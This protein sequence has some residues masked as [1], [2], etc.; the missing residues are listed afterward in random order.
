MSQIDF[1]RC[2]A[3]LVAVRLKIRVPIGIDETADHPALTEL[4]VVAEWDST[5]EAFVTEIDIRG[6]ALQ[7]CGEGCKFLVLLL[8]PSRTLSCHL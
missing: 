4:L 6:L 3:R 5:E 7:Q 2:R 1:E 8:S